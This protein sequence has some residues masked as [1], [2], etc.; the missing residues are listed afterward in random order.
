[1][2]FALWSVLVVGTLVGAF[3]LARRLWRSVVA[4][5]R[6]LARAGE[7]ASELATR[8]EQLAELAARERPDTSATLFTDRDELRAAVWRLRADRRAR[9][10][11]RAEQ[12]AA[13]ARGWRTYWT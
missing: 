12:H 7:A 4:L 13:T 11:A 9:R 8:A 1:M 6:E 2:W 3:F 5:G 10:E